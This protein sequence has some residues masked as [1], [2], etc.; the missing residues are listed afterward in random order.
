[1]LRNH[2]GVDFSLY[3]P[4]TIKRRIT[5]RMVLNRSET[6]DAYARFLRGNTQEMDLLYSDLLINVTS[7]FRNPEAFE[8]LKG[9]VFPKLLHRRGEDPVRMW[10]IGCSTGQEAY[11]LAMAWIEF[12]E[13]LTHAPKLQIFATDLNEAMLEKARR[14]HYP[15]SVLQDVSAERLRR[16]FVEEE[17]GYRITKA[18]RDICLFA[19][20]NLLTDPPFSRM[21]LVSC[22]NLL[23]Y[24]QPDLQQKILP[25][26]HYALK[27]E[28]L[29]I[30]GGI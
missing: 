19:R 20:Q 7:F 2:F 5:R 14:G 17:G 24:I 25:A 30:S 12:S 21:D 15:T 9:K 1:M 16:F 8:T 13:T 23:I 26:L 11:S 4:T 28:W 29:F 22:R 6:L 3:K 10:V 18:L 27:P